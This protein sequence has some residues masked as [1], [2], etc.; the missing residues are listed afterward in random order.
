MGF[1]KACLAEG[2]VASNE[3]AVAANVGCLS[4]NGV[5]IRV[6]EDKAA[7]LV[8]MGCINDD[9]AITEVNGKPE[10]D[11]KIWGSILT[12]ACGVNAETT[13]VAFKWIALFFLVYFEN[14]T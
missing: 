9:T 7:C 2:A 4:G 14:F 3:T 10:E 11:F 1:S 5:I 12:L 13:T 8:A 6:A